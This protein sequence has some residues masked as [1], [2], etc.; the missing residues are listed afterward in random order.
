M[1]TG[2]CFGNI[3]GEYWHGAFPKIFAL[4]MQHRHMVVLEGS[5]YFLTK[6]IFVKI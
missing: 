6:F 1:C 4:V 3:V 2:G 5:K